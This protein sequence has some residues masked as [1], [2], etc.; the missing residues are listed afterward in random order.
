MVIGTV[1]QPV[2]GAVLMAMELAGVPLEEHFIDRLKEHP[3][4]IP[5][6]ARL[7]VDEM[8]C[9]LNHKKRSLRLHL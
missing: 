5:N 4:A 9:S 8:G 6:K 1:T 3:R 2:L 7:K